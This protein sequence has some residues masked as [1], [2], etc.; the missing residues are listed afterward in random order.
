MVAVTTLYGAIAMAAPAEPLQASD[1]Q[2]VNG[3]TIRVLGTTVSV[4]GYDVP[5]MRRRAWCSRERD[6]GERAAARLRELLA[7]GKSSLQMMPCACRP[8]TEGT[9]LCNRGRACGIL[10]VDGLQVG[11]VLIKEGLAKPFICGERRCPRRKI[12]RWCER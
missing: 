7:G 9:L 1:V 8:G 4:I 10:T 11:E 5:A 6:M 2:V 3:N 12:G